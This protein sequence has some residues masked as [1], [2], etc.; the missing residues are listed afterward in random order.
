MAVQ[1]VSVPYHRWAVPDNIQPL[2]GRILMSYDDFRAYLKPK[3]S[4][5]EVDSAFYELSSQEKI[6][7]MWNCEVFAS[8]GFRYGEF[9]RHLYFRPIDRKKPIVF[10]I[11]GVSSGCY[12]MVV[13]AHMPGKKHD[14]MVNFK[15]F[16]TDRFLID[17]DDGA[18][19]G[20]NDRVSDY[21]SITAGGETFVYRES[22]PSPHRQNE[23]IFPNAWKLD[24][25]DP[26]CAFVGGELTANQLRAVAYRQYMEAEKEIRREVHIQKL[27]H[28]NA[29]LQQDVTEAQLDGLQAKFKGDYLLQGLRNIVNDFWPFVSHKRIAALIKVVETTYN[30]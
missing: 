25:A 1:I 10:A 29:E 16:K 6:H 17:C 15:P 21:W 4:N 8:L 11:D 2:C 28:R 22:R 13:D 9:T 20:S 19:I 14:R 27:A 23:N 26:L 24:S 3:D 12:F 5:P 30:Q 7:G 18:G